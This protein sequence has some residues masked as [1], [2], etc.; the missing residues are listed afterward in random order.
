MEICQQL[1]VIC[2]C[3]QNLILTIL[4]AIRAVW[5]SPKSQSSSPLLLDPLPY[6]KLHHHKSHTV[7]CMPSGQWL[8]QS[9]LATSPNLTF[10]L[11]HF[12]LELE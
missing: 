8:F 2:T 9:F 5:Q 10:V 11:P 6:S 4:S 1:H 12:N 3:G 7:N